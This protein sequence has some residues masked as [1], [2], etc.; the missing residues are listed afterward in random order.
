MNPNAFLVAVRA[1]WQAALV[2]KINA[3]VQVAV[4]QQEMS[5][6]RMVLAGALLATMDIFLNLANVLTIGARVKMAQV[7]PGQIAKRTIH[8]CAP[9]ATVVSHWMGTCV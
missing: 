2:K 6:L 5:A 8:R 3:L 9:L 7:Q 1:R 4:Q